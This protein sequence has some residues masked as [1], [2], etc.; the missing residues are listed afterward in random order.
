M[1]KKI[2]QSELEPILAIISR[3]PLG[4]S[5]DEIVRGLTIP[6]ARRTLQRR[7][8]M[9]VE[10]QSINRFGA[11][12]GTRYI[13]KPYPTSVISSAVVGAETAA[14]EEG[15][16][17]LPITA[18]AEKIK[19]LVR[20][21][22]QH[23]QPVGYNRDFLNDYKPNQSYYLSPEI[24]QHLQQIGRSAS[25]DQPAGT[26]AKQVYQRLLID[27]SWN[28]SRLE[29]NTYSL[30]ETERLLQSGHSADGKQG[31][32]T[33]MILNHKAAIE[34]LVEQA[35]ETGFNHYTLLNLHA[36]L[37]DNLL[38]N[39]LAC[40]RLREIAVGIGGTVFHPLEVPQ[41][42]DEC[43]TQ[44]LHTASAI[45]DPFEQ[46][47]FV[48]VQLPYLQPF[49]DV[50][51]RVS[52]LAANL[53][54]IKHN[55]SPLSFIDVPNKTYIEGILGVYEL[56]QPEL[57]RDLFVWAYERS[58]AR[59]A[60]VQQSLGDPDPFR[61]RH[62]ELIKTLVHHLVISRMDKQHATIYIRQQAMQHLPKTEQTRFI[63]VI[64]SEA[65]SLHEGNIARYKLRPS[66]Y[67]EWKEGWR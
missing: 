38:P 62:R 25:S 2:K 45:H 42:I 32:E 37:A 7:L 3:Y 18:E 55:L 60:A 8:A 34:L 61:L 24:R 26:H 49:E 33:Q 6:V 1:P 56:N 41:L 17:Y 36:L 65:L 67:A 27:L 39:Q 52:R 20:R 5:V 23:R 58:C 14:A 53:P 4:V 16:V 48:M 57:L 22:L 9:L 35:E 15:E 50:N 12:R 54:L 43:F 40:G 21:P 30:L 46:A 29:G 63:E 31:V 19:Q 64:E 11:G 44:I 10:K 28:S 59:Y 13:P 66:Q 51:K 47:F